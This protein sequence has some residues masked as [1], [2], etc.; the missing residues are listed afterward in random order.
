MSRE[1][2]KKAICKRINSYVVERT[3]G[4]LEQSVIPDSMAYLGAVVLPFLSVLLGSDL[5]S[6]ELMTIAALPLRYMSSV[7]QL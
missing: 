4:E 7:L 3:N 5:V 6:F 2:Y 1:A